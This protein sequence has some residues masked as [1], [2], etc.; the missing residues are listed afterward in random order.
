MKKQFFEN[1]HKTDQKLSLG[2]II[3][4]ILEVILVIG[5]KSNEWFPLINILLIVLILSIL[6]KDYLQRRSFFEE[7]RTLAEEEKRSSTLIH[8]MPDFVCFKDGE[9]RW[10]QVN[11]FGRKLYELEAVDYRGKTDA[12]LGSFTPFF[13]EALESCV[14]SDE[15]TWVKRELTRNEES[16]YVPSGELK[17]FDVIKV[18][19][20]FENGE[21]KGLVTIGRDISQQKVAESL[22]L[23]KEKLSVAGEL[24][25]GIAHEIRNPLTSLK[26]FIQLLEESDNIPEKYLSVMSSEIERINRIVSELLVLAKPQIKTLETLKTIDMIQYTMN[27][28]QHEALLKGIEVRLQNEAEESC[29]FGDQSQL[30]QV[31]INILKNAMES[32][33]KSGFIHILIKEV[34]GR[35]EVSVNDQGVGISPAKLKNVGEP[36]FT[37]KEKGMGLGLTISHKIIHEHKGSIKIESVEGIGTTVRISLPLQNSSSPN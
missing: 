29:V 12:E 7:F 1:I 18:P 11:E 28:M 15:E 17:T 2:V 5:F 22:L 35:V 14:D 33:G 8:S 31:F 9:G 25:A 37:L 26:G 13:K 3:L 16:F 23:K 19:L 20:F 30:V 34:E 6:I 27:V 4:L 32:M 36:F 21:R 10:V 24:A